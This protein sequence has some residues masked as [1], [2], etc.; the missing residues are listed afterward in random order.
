MTIWKKSIKNILK[1]LIYCN[2]MIGHNTWLRQ[3]IF[4]TNHILNK[5][6]WCHWWNLLIF[7]LIKSFSFLQW[8]LLFLFCL[9]EILCFHT[10]FKGFGLNLSC[11]IYACS[12]IL[13]NFKCCTVCLL[14]VIQWT[15][16]IIIWLTKYEVYLHITFT[17][18][19][20]VC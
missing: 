14:R 7:W 18:V 17:S 6:S 20:S 11:L 19:H 15:R 5:F 13:P 10:K 12:I 16:F 1:N 4:K 9:H 2:Q 3:R 8:K